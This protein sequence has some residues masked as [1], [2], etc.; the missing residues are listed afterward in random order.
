MKNFLKLSGLK[1]LA[2]T[3]VL[4]SSFASQAHADFYIPSVEASV[5]RGLIM[6]VMLKCTGRMS[7]KKSSSI[8]SF[9]KSSK[10]FCTAKNKCYS[11][12]RAAA[13]ES[14]NSDETVLSRLK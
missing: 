2:L 13:I 11:T 6:E 1:G 3:G 4:L 12:A 10:K 14:C 9:D 8:M 5:D 7:G